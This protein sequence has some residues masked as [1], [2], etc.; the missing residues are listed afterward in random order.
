[1]RMRKCIQGALALA[2]SAL[3]GG[4]SPAH[5]QV[6]STGIIEVVVTDT[7]GGA[8]P[9]ATVSVSATDTVT[10]R[11]SVTNA[12]LSGRNRGVCQNS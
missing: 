6:A 11:S 8:I 9:G 3:L 5:A 4:L 7:Q 12:T 1:M 2:L 10:S